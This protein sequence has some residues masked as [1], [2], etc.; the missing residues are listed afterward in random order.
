MKTVCEKNNCAACS[1]CTDVCPQRAIHIEDNLSSFNALID[2]KKC[3]KCNLCHSKCP[4]N[5]HVKKNEPIA[6]YQGFTLNEEMRSKASSGGVGTE[7]IRWFIEQGGYVASCI[8]NNGE[9]RFIVSNDI[10]SIRQFSGSKYVKSN[11][12]GVYQQVNE[13][14]LKK[15]KVLFIGLPCQCAALKNYVNSKYDEYLYLVD[16]ICHGTP[17][18]KLLDLFLNQYSKS[19]KSISDIKFRLKAKMQIV[20]DDEGIVCKGVTDKYTT[21]FLSGL[22][23]TDNCYNCK[24]ACEERCSDITIGDSWGSQM[25]VEEQKKGI[26]LLLIQTVKG[27]ELIKNSNVSLY[28]VDKKTAKKNNGQLNAPSPIPSGRENFFQKLS[29]DNFNKLIFGRYPIKCLKQDI[30]YIL[31]K[32]NI[33]NR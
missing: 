15:N 14:L 21:A 24:Y 9:F 8:F 6:W 22:T 1:L 19:L 26:S 13:L 3:I 5:N 2:T 11:P 4:Q 20:V 29:N 33:I 31:I 32:L 28:S 12:Q 18:P 27:Q 10:K 30:K 17:S 23:Y 16:L 7:L 25:S